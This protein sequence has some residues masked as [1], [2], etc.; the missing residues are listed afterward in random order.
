MHFSIV[1]IRNTPNG[2][3]V[4]IRAGRQVGKWQLAREGGHW[5]IA[6]IS[7]V[8]WMKGASILKALEL[9]NKRGR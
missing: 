6:D 9:E 4:T 1:A 7:E 3:N 8:G 2:V 5:K